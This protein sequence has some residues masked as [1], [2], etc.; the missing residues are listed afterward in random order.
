MKSEKG[1]F[2]IIIP[3]YNGVNFLNICFKS[4]R[5][6]SYKNI[7]IIMVD[8]NS[9]DNSV[10]FTIKYFPEIKVINN[11]KNIGFASSV[12]NGIKVARGEYIALL[13]NDTEVAKDWIYEIY[14]AVNK[15]PDASF[16]AS[17]MLDFADRTIIDSC[18]DSMTWSG[19]SYKRMEGQKNNRDLSP[20]FVFGACAGASIYKKSLFDEI[21]LFDEDFKFYLE[22]VDIDFRAQLAGFKCLFVPEAVVYHV[23]SGTTGKISPFSFKMV[24][25]NHFHLIYKNFPIRMIWKNLIK[26][27]YSEFRFFLASIK[28]HFIKEYFWGIAHALLEHAKMIPKRKGIQSSRK[29][30]IKYLDTVVE[31][32][33]IYKSITESIKK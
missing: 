11:K 26:I 6:Q 22:D 10:E 16:F 3:N 25:K 17:K 24:I 31:N 20:T 30:S 5:K 4:I 7:E 2:S 27:F 13:N 9:T 23:G 15:Y 33:F 32:N 29:V 28:H 12:N 8:D 21:G 19:R 18:G 14:K 1:L